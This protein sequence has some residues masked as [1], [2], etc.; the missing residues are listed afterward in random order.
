MVVLVATCLCS[1]RLLRWPFAEIELTQLSPAHNSIFASVLPL[2]GPLPC[3]M[4]TPP[5]AVAQQ[6]D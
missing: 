1:S 2:I 3:G 6:R 4:F 5:C